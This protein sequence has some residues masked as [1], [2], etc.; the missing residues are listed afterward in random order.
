MDKDTF[1]RAS[2]IE[3]RIHDNNLL[4]SQIDIFRQNVPSTGNC[5]ISVSR[6]NGERGVADWKNI[7][8]PSAIVLEMLSGYEH[9]LAS[10]NDRLTEDFAKL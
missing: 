2:E 6:F 10:E 8:L 7:C 3:K 1:M 4:L 9:T 5:E